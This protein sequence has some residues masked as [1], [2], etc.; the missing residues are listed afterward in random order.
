MTEIDEVEATRRERTGTHG[1][2]EEVARLSCAWATTFGTS[3]NVGSRRMADDQIMA[4]DEIFHK[5]ARIASGDPDHDDHWKDVEGY[6]RLGRRAAARR[7]D[8][9]SM[10]ATDADRAS[11]FPDLLGIDESREHVSVTGERRVVLPGCDLRGR[12]YARADQVGAGTEVE[13]DDGFTCHP[14][15]R[16]RVWW[17]DEHGLYVRC[18]GSPSGRHFLS[19]QLS[20]D[21]THYVG[22]YL[23]PSAR[24]PATEDEVDARVVAEAAEIMRRRGWA[25]EGKG[26]ARVARQIGTFARPFGAGTCGTC[27]G[28]AGGEPPVSDRSPVDVREFVRNM[29]GDPP[30]G[31][32][33]MDA[34]TRERVARLARQLGGDPE[35]HP[36]PDDDAG[37]RVGYAPRD[38]EAMARCRRILEDMGWLEAAQAVRRASERVVAGVGWRRS[39]AGNLPPDD[40]PVRPID[41]ATD[42]DVLWRASEI[43]A[44]R[45][46]DELAR[47]VRAATACD[48]PR[49]GGADRFSAIESGQ[50]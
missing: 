9:P 46:M 3:R 11:Q 10:Q 31:F 50:N 17:D 48:P 35:E 4:V 45:G 44:T 2:F 20:D 14:V 23:A 27:G 40:A 34:G 19:G 38:I 47:K 6:A 8:A 41:A 12:P 24:A 25:E 26:A 22:V 7:R 49:G 33:R 39:Q 18:D 15:R 30:E 42:F 32:G 29:C 21:G 43:I 5:I 16:Q 36:S 1:P 37:A 28:D 13:L